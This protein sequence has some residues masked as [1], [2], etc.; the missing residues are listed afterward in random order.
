MVLLL[1][2]VFLG[3]G[4]SALVLYNGTPHG[5][6]TSTCAPIN[7]FDHTFVVNADCRWVSIGELAVVAVFFF[8]AV[9]AV[10]VARTKPRVQQ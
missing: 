6:P 9:L 10:L 8:A 4:I 1:A 3:I 2:I 5:G 7:F